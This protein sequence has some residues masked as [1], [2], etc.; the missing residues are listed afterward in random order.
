MPF[1]LSCVSPCLTM[2]THNLLDAQKLPLWDWNNSSYCIRSTIPIGSMGLMYVV[3]TFSIKIHHLRRVYIRVPWDPSWDI[4]ESSWRSNHEQQTTPVLLDA[5][6]SW[7]HRAL[8]CQQPTAPSHFEMRLVADILEGT[9]KGIMW[10]SKFLYT[11]IQIVCTKKKLESTELF[12][13]ITS[14]LSTFL[15][16]TIALSIHFCHFL[17]GYQEWIK[18]NEMTLKPK[19]PESHIP[20][21]NLSIHSPSRLFF[22]HT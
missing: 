22:C 7:S 10:R 3:P 12:R 11:V 18:M 1:L 8:W 15:S 2:E 13:N 6:L 16:E 9:Q 5:D 20:W 4:S 19:S 17:Q 14:H 21:L